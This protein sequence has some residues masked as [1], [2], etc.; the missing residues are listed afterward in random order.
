VPFGNPYLKKAKIA[1]PAVDV[2]SVMRLNAWPTSVPSRS[3]R[4]GG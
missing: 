4:R 3:A 2:I 1:A